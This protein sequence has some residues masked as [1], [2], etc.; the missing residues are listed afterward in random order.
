MKTIWKIAAPV[1]VIAAGVA[2]FPTLEAAKPDPDKKIEANRPVSLFVEDVRREKV[3]LE[4]ATQGEVRPLTQVDLIPQVSGRIIAVADNFSE[5]AGFQPGET[6]LQIDPSD[7]EL[8]LTRAESR[9]AEARVT[10][11]QELADQRIKQ[12]QWKEWVKD[13][14]P[15]D[16]ALN[17]PQVARAQAAL[18]A[19]EADLREA[20]LNLERTRISLPFEGRVAERAVS[21]GQFVRAGDNLGQVFATDAVEVRLPLSDSQLADLNLPLGFV[22]KS[23]DTAP[24]VTLTATL[25]GQ[26]RHW[27]GR[28]V[29]TH[30]RIDQESRLAFAVARVD[31]PY[32]AGTSDG[33]P[34]PVGLFV[35]AGVEGAT[36][37]DAL[38]MPRAAL[39]SEN[40]VYVI[41]G[42]NTLSIR[43]VTV[44]SS[45]ADRV[46]VKDGLKAGDRVVTSP[47][48]AAV[49][50][51]KVEPITRS[52]EAVPATPDR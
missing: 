37:T 47:V 52:A 38:V 20:E 29:R 28:I 32:G 17:K 16:L 46:L 27:Q 15:T 43:E 31:D 34:L 44:L 7:Y 21:L 24:E 40:T 9:V 41:A 50:G 8:A 4:V 13:G 11:E 25:G 12:K 35:Q 45:N 30:A 19:A 2:T 18:R 1:V 39:R 36:R 42:D 22:A 14:N 10:L 51:M 5:G 26:V 48:R 3:T 49:D 23:M 33:M 6:L